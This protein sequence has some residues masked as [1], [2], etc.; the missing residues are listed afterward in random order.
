V[1]HT[2][3]PDVKSLTP[4]AQAAQL[5]PGGPAAYVRCATLSG[6]GSMTQQMAGQRLGESLRADAQQNR[7]RIIEVAREA[8]AESAD[9]SL[10]SIAKKAGVG[11][12]TL[13]RHFPTRE[14]LVL[15]VYRYDVQ[16]LADAA[17]ALLAEHPPLTALRMWF[18][19]LAYCGRIKH[20]LADALQAATSDGLADEAYEPLV[21]AIGTLLAACERAGRIRP[22]LVPDDVLLLLGF[23]WRIDDGDGAAAKASR[24]LGLV[25]DA[26]RAGAPVPQAPRRA[27]WFRRGRRAASA[28]R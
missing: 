3:E 27:A 21:G 24:L 1:I 18:E 11:A 2:G 28:G 7:Q 20:G 17:A 26:L 15:A 22:G 12:G 14:A 13:Y 25:M 6:G 5:A 9:A 16:Q 8:F 4:R 23:L 19:R 10:N